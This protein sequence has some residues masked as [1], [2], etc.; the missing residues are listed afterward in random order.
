MFFLYI[1]YYVFFDEVLLLCFIHFSVRNI[2][3]FV[4]KKYIQKEESLG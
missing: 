2:R 3:Y 1:Y 4:V